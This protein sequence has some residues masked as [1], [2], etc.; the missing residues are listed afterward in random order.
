M[1]NEVSAWAAQDG[2]LHKTKVSALEADALS[3]L[4]RL[5]IFNQGS[6]LAIIREAEAIAKVLFPLV[7]ERELVEEAAES[8]AFENSAKQPA[9][10]PK[11]ESR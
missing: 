8:E 1:V 6:A 5:Q 2:T 7:L 10:P 11:S 4:M 3:S 9:E